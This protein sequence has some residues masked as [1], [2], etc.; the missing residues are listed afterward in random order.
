MNYAISKEIVWL[1]Y[2]ELKVVGTL[3]LENILF[4]EE[5]KQVLLAMNLKVFQDVAATV[6]MA[7]IC[8]STADLRET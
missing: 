7:N 3:T 1:E 4:I 2:S 6:E 5:N 8:Q